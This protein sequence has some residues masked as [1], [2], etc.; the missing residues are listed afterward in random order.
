[1]LTQIF[2]SSSLKSRQQVQAV[3]P[4]LPDFAR[5]LDPKI[6][7]LVLALIGNGQLPLYSCEGHGLA[8]PRYVSMAF[9]SE[10]ARLK[11]CQNLSSAF[12]A[13]QL[14]MEFRSTLSTETINGECFVHETVQNEV[15]GVNHL[16]KLNHDRYWFVIL[17][18]GRCIEGDVVAGRLSF[19][20]HL[21]VATQNLF[22]AAYNLCFRKRITARLTRYLYGV[23]P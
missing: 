17:Y 1:M 15:N 8:K 7:D 14:R 16:Y 4:T 11:F 2:E 18:I 5:Y 19:A 21:S 9:S 12:A 6:C 20:R 23:K 3:S 13:K 22:N 10:Q